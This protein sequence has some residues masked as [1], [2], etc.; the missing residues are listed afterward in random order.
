MK[1]DATILNTF[2][3]LYSFDYEDAGYQPANLVKVLHTIFLSIST[4]T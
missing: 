4:I 1:I 3:F 2:H